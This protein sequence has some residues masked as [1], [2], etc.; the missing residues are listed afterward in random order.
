LRTFCT[1]L[2]ACSEKREQNYSKKTD[3]FRAGFAIIF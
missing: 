3:K 1:R 2:I